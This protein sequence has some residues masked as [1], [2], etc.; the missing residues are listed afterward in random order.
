MSASPAIDETI[1]RAVVNDVLRGL[2]AQGALPTAAAPAP[3]VAPAV[4]APRR[5]SRFGLFTEVNTACHAAQDAFLRLQ[6][7]GLAGRAKVIEIVK[8][9]A[10]RHAEEWGRIEFEE[11]KIGRL[12]HKVE[13]LQIVKL[14]PGLEWLRPYALSGDHGITLEE[15]TPFGVIGAITP[16]T[17]SVPTICGNIVAMVAAGNAVV[18]NPHPGGA[19]CAAIAV[20][21]INEAIH[22]ALGI[23]H[24]VCLLVEP[25]LKTFDALCQHEHVRLLCVTGGPAVVNAAMKSGK[26]AICAGP[27]N[28]PVVV[29]GTGNLAKA[30]ADIIKGAAYDNN[31]LCIGEKQIFVLESVAE[32]FMNELAVA[33]AAKLTAPQLAK[34]TAAAFTTSKDA[35]GCSHAVLNSLAK[36]PPSSP[37]TPGPPSR[38][39]C[40]CSS[41]RPMPTTRS[42]TRSR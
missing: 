18:F 29:D 37:S 26:R 22:A 40:R 9:L 19:R 4:V 27:G 15:Q 12:A 5:E 21:A 23:E 3:V 13:K 28:P 33:G 34:L 7:H 8:D 20:R 16:V 1:L 41:P 14:V 39:R 17:H 38:P 36:T 25:T 6:T 32:R 30:A 2:R 31:L 42:F 24:L 11:T 10:T 35:G